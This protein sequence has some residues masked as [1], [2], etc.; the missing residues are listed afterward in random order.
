M[1]R[2]SHHSQPTDTGNCQI[3][4]VEV[5]GPY[6]VT[7]RLGPVNYVISTPERRKTCRVCHVKLL[8]PYRQ[9]DLVLFP[10]IEPLPVCVVNEIE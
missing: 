7:E 1:R 8:R 9:R 10:D 6:I 5:H 2:W 4:T 3:V